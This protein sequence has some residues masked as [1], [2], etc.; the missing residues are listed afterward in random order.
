MFN[1]VNSNFTLYLRLKYLFLKVYSN[2]TDFSIFPE[3]IIQVCL[4]DIF[5]SKI[6]LIQQVN[7]AILETWYQP[8]FFV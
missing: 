5:M 2:T 4:G 7:F 6:T 8:V 1:R 3:N